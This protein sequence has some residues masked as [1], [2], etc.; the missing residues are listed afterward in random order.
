[1]FEQNDPYRLIMCGFIHCMFLSI[2][3]KARLFLLLQH[4]FGNFVGRVKSTAPGNEAD[5]GANL[6][7]SGRGHDFGARTAPPGCP[8]ET[9]RDAEQ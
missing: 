6:S 4:L 5:L 9:P 8:G 3:C 7:R 1:M 2:I